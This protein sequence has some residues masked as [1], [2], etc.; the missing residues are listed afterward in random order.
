MHLC[1]D[2][3]GVR[4][5]D[6]AAIAA[7]F[8]AMIFAPDGIPDQGAAIERGEPMRTN[9]GR[10]RNRPVLLAVHQDMHACDA[11]GPQRA[12]EFDSPCGCVPCVMMK[13]HALTPM[14]VG[15]LCGLAPDVRHAGHRLS[16]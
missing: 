2:A 11:A 4:V 15:R 6:T 13:D 8:K 5:V 9:V 10:G 1:V 16:P 3:I 14:S 7:E 12:I